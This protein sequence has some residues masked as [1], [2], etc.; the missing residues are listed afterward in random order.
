V[1]PAQ[2][3]TC[4]FLPYG[5]H[6][7][8]RRQVDAVDEP[9]SCVTFWRALRGRR[10]RKRAS[11]VP[12][13]CRDGNYSGRS[14]L[15][16]IARGTV[17]EVFMMRAIPFVTIAFA[18][19]SLSTV[20]AYAAP[21]CA[22]YSGKGGTNCGFYSFQQCQAAVSGRGGFCR[23]NAF[24]AYGSAGSAYGSVRQPRGRYQSR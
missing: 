20:G 4:G 19:L 18:A 12:R 15:C 22:D 10:V 2:I 24:E 5:S 3:R 11:G 8:Y 1:P 13:A 9:T 17:A 21:W 16:L 23:T 6:L 7:G 14:V